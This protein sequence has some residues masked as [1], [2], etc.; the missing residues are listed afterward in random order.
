MPNLCATLR[1]STAGLPEPARIQAVRELHVSERAILS[2][3]LEPI[4]PLEPLPGCLLDVDL[5]KRT[6]PG[7]AV[8]AGEFCGLRHA[9]CRRGAPANG[10]DDLFL[11]ANVRGRCT[12]RQRDRELQIED[13]EAF[14]ATRDETTIAIMRP[15]PTFWV[16][17]RVPREPVA[18]LLG[19]LGDTPISAVSRDTEA[20]RL[21]ISY[22][23][24]IAGALPLAT[25]E[26]QRLAACH[27]QD[28]LAAIVRAARDGRSIAEGRGIAAARLCAIMRDIEARIGEDDLSVGK[29]A[30][31][32]RITPRYVHKLFE[33]EGL[34]F[35]S[36]VLGQRLSRAHRMLS[37]PCR[38]ERNISTIAFAV[39]FGDLSYFN[40]AFRRHYGV[41]P[42]DVRQSSARADPPVIVSQ[43]R[44]STT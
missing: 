30:S 25:A 16:G 20:L 10:G 33:D 5:T 36:F 35:S 18:L 43:R 4:E 24:A 17:C 21:F 7:L 22:A 44:T 27:V 42:S 23:S 14:L 2:G 41:T 9:I 34:T 38:P 28:L 6:V 3:N 13:G 40:R 8:V 32:H 12:V 29:I 31:R 37:D 15:T 1:F 19:R 11:V 26:L 39:G